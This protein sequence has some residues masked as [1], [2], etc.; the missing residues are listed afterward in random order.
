MQ[1]LWQVSQS[2]CL[3]YAERLAGLRR[4]A[5]PVWSTRLQ[6][7]LTVLNFHR[8]SMNNWK[9]WLSHQVL[10][11]KASTFNTQ[12]LT[13]WKWWVLTKK[14]NAIWWNFKINVQKLTDICGFELQNFTQKDL[15]K[16]KIFQKVLVGLLFWNPLYIYKLQTKT[17]TALFQKVYKNAH[18]LIVVSNNAIFTLLSYV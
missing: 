8:L 12:N 15:T 3:V 4:T 2:H 11:H 17:C 18:I 6:T 7:F 13:W 9:W 1:T 5:E 14:N 10:A 16:V